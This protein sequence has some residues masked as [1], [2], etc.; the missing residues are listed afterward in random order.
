MSTEVGEAY[1]QALV[2]NQAGMM[3][4]EAGHPDDGLRMLQMGQV[5]SW[6]IP[7]D[8][9]RMV[10][11]G[12]SGRAAL[13]SC[14]LADS[15]TALAALGRADLAAAEMTKARQLWQP[16]RSDPL[17]DPGR[18]AAR[19]EL[20][21]GRLDVAE[22]HAAA[23]VRRWEGVSRGRRTR[24][25]IVLATVY[26][27]GGEPKGLTMAKTVIDAVARL[28][29]PRTRRQLVPLADALAARPGADACEL[30]RMARKVAARQAA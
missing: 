17:G 2:L 26:V 7:R 27:A 30:A 9:R 28:D 19:L 12:E 24:S 23:S 18:V 1:L 3:T 16:G 29:S 22:Q 4:T 11:V 8:D 20:D 6:R 15:A 25:G 13:E 21:R 5:T 10:V 14:A